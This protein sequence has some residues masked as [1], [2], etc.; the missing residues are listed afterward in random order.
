MKVIFLADVQGKGKQGEIKN[1][2]DGYARNYLLPKQLAEEATAGNIRAAEEK[3]KKERQKAADA[4]KDAE[5]LKND[6]E[7]RTVEIKAK[8]GD[9]GHLFGS[10]TNKHIA[11][12]LKQHGIHVDK[13]KIDLDEPIRSLGYA[14]VPV[15]IHPDVQ[16][17]IKVHV[18][19]GK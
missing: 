11:D 13:R 5:T 7:K 1:V 4:R 18:V 17:M 10:V 2:P 8:S 16:A 6:I 14:N 12:E 9:K 19:E 3:K 15:K